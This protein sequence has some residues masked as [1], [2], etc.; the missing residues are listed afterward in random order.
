MS[1]NLRKKVISW[2]TNLKF[3]RP[4]RSGGGKEKQNLS[5]QNS[6][7]ER[8]RERQAVTAL[9]QRVGT[10]ISPT[11]NSIDKHKFLW[12]LKGNFRVYL[13]NSRGKPTNL[14]KWEDEKGTS[15][16]RP[17]RR[18]TNLERIL[19]RARGST[20]DIDRYHQGSFFLYS[21]CT[22]KGQQERQWTSQVGER[23]KKNRK[24]VRSGG[25]KRNIAEVSGGN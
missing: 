6:E 21:A 7:G 10:G 20:G 11:K 13:K 9:E 4:P 23:K 24:R 22:N 3:D 25:G 2:K 18:N 5:R 15:E 17:N 16:R 14:G 1:T 8:T 19:G 12:P